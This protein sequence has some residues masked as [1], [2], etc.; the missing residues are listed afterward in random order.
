MSLPIPLTVKGA[1]SDANQ[2]VP[3]PGTLL[4]ALFGAFFAYAGRRRW[5]LKDAL[6]RIKTAVLHGETAAGVTV[7]GPDY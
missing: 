4:L 1:L 3:E 2:A 7:C 6:D 5:S